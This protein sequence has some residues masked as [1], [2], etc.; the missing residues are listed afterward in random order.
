MEEKKKI[1][2]IINPI[3]GVYKKKNIPEKIAR[4]I[5]YVKYDYTIRFTQYAGHA[6]LIAQQAVAEGYHVC[7]AVGGDGSI[8]EVAQSLIGTET[9]LGVIPYG[10]GNGFATHLKIPPRDAEGALKVLNTGKV[11]KIDL[12]KSNIR[13][14]VS[15][16]GFGIDSSVARRFHHHAIRGL[17][18]Y[19]WAVVKELLLYFKPFE[20]KVEIDDVVLEKEFFLFTAFNS[21]Q[22]GY[23]YAVFPFTSMKDGV[24]D[25]I[26][27][28]RFPVWKL[29]YIVACLMLKRADLIKEAESYR[30]KR[31]KIHGSK[32]MV[33]QFDGDSVIWH[34]D[35]IFEA[36]PQCINMI[37][38]EGLNSY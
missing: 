30:A 9:A 12:I 35:V 33:Y 26:V 27:M 4:Y 37:V 10:S 24:M 5:D 17:A 3:S 7:V 6:T 1:M 8:N 34:D 31:I 25:V 29:F 21:N 23:D 22:Y 28:N 15:N 13:Y 19:A 32:K 16:A 18:S 36:V 11:V 20:A 38:P 14:V 2:F